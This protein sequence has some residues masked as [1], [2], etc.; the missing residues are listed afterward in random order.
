MVMRKFLLVL[1]AVLLTTAYTPS[2]TP[3]AAQAGEEAANPSG[4][5]SPETKADY[6]LLAD[7]YADLA[8]AAQA[9]AERHRKMAASYTGGMKATY[10]EHMIKHCDK[11]VILQENL[12]AEYEGL[13][14]AYQKEAAGME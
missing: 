10:R 1:T 9:E 8:K 6:A 7:K 2:S 13:A 11:I 3:V 4:L 5:P 12:A 14:E